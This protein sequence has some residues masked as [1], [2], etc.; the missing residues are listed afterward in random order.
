MTDPLDEK[1]W[2]GKRV[3]VTGGC[4]FIGSHIVDKLIGMGSEVTVFDNLSSSTTEY[5]SKYFEHDRFRFFKGDLRNV[6]DLKGAMEGIDMVIHLAA[7]PD[8]RGSVIKPI[9]NF[10]INV[11]GTM[12]VLETMRL[13]D[14]DRIVFASSGGTLYGEASKFPIDE[15]EPPRPISP[16]GAS[17][18]AAEMY[19]SAYAS[20]Y[21]MSAVSLRY[22]NIFGPRSSHGVMYDFFMKL[23]KDKR[24]LEILGNGKQKKSYLYVSDCVSASLMVSE[25]MAKGYD[26]F[27]IGSEEWITVNEIA[28]IICDEL[29]LKEVTFKYT[30]G[31]RGW[32]GD[33]KKVLLSIEKIKKLGWEP[34]VRLR[35]GIRLYVNWLRSKYGWP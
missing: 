13:K 18:A 26:A 22:A 27:N 11:D 20:C 29:G 10:K 7:D 32:T 3:L 9:E 1:F 30:G 24:T 33:V 16:Y 19:L 35:D 6:E 34:K 15:G 31:E 5:I 17:K 23:K 25:R 12:N 8:V 4:G 2:Y 14:V 21:G 28:R